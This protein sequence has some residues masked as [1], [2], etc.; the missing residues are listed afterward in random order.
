[1]ILFVFVSIIH[2]AVITT[3]RSIPPRIINITAVIMSAAD[4]LST[5]LMVAVT[6]NGIDASEAKRIDQVNIWIQIVVSC[7]ECVVDSCVPSS[8]SGKEL[9]LLLGGVGRRRGRRD[10]IAAILINHRHRLPLQFIWICITVVYTA[11]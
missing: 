6:A 1:M 4:A 10:V 7:G 5:G 9:S 8:T 2:Y 11:K 3:Q